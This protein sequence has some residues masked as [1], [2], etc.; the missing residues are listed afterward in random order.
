MD[1]NNTSR[2]FFFNINLLNI[3]NLKINILI[4]CIW[5]DINAT[6]QS[7]PPVS[8]RFQ[9]IEELFCLKT[10]VVAQSKSSQKKEMT[11]SLLDSKRSLAV[12]IF[13][14]QF[15]CPVKDI[16][17]HINQCDADFFTAE[18]LDCLQ[19]VLPE[20]E[21]VRITILVNIK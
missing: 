9:Q 8:L 6:I 10:T 5:K 16:A 13:L 11:L 18:Q 1:K 15:K 7:K 4:D 12:N 3:L 17:E 19:K 21:E 20:P 2:R 14:K